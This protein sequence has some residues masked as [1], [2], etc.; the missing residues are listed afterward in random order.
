[1]NKEIKLVPKVST[2]PV[3]TTLDL[4]SNRVLQSAL[5][6]GVT[7]AVV[8]GYDKDGQFYFAS[9]KADGGDVLWLIETAKLKLLG[10]A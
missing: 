1:M 5:D 3:V 9:S 10:V 6:A 4:D 2:L 8:M 7:S